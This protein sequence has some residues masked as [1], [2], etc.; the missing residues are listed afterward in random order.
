MKIY[1]SYF[2]KTKSLI[3]NNIIPISI[4]LFTPKYLKNVI[5]IHLKNLA[6]T[7]TMLSMDL[8]IYIPKYKKILTKLNYDE[9]IN[10]ISFFAQNKDCALL[11]YE[12]PEDFCHRHLLAEWLNE[13]TEFDIKEW[14][15]APKKKKIEIKQTVLF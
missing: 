15:E 14:I 12:I 9:V 1:T 3:E 13:N 8:D 7:Y 10:D 4:S 11:C 5:K 2:A 6:P